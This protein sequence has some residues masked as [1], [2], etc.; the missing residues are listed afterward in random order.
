MTVTIEVASEAYG[1][2][3]TKRAVLLSEEHRTP[4]ALEKA[5]VE[6][7]RT[8]RKSNEETL[9]SYLPTAAHEA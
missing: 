7:I 9:K 3:S 5:A 4:E 2:T 1:A 6:F 8:A